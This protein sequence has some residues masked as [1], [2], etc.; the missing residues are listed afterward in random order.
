MFPVA[1]VFS[2]IGAYMRQLKQ[3][4]KTSRISRLVLMPYRMRAALAYYAAPVARIPVWL[5]TSK[6]YTNFTYDLSELNREYLAWFVA[7]VTQKSVNAVRSY[8]AELES[9]HDLREHVRRL[10]HSSEFRHVSDADARFARRAGWYAFVRAL[11]PRVV[12]ESGID[13]GLGSCVLA[14]ALRRNTAEG[15]AGYLYAIDIDPKAGYLFQAP[16]TD[17]GRIL[18]GDSLSVLQDLNERI[19]LFI[20]DSRHS[21][22]HERNEF[23][24]VASKLEPKAL[25][26]SDNAHSTGELMAFAERTRRQFLFF[27]ERP[28][29]HWYPGGG[30]G[31]AFAM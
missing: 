19:D 31:A 29:L 28:S 16:Y 30:I 1:R 13:K 20:H 18:Y 23:E 8:T 22:E 27:Q 17:C 24:L 14:S 21:P 10:T 26:L 6:E 25:V 4:L 9:D 5:L 7:V 11:K 2:Q 3:L 15:R 12:V